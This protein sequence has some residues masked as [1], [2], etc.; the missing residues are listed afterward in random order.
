MVLVASLFLA[1]LVFLVPLS[2]PFLPILLCVLVVCV[3]LGWALGGRGGR[4]LHGVGW[5]VGIPWLV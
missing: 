5:K 3:H 1:H 4:E 2:R